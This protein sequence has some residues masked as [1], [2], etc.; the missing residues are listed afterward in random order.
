MTVVK[1]KKLKL[2]KKN[3]LIFLSCILLIL[4]SITYGV[5]TLTSPKTTKKEKVVKTA[6]EIKL[7][8][9][10]NIQKK[11]DY[12]NEDYIDRYLA[13]QKK[14]K[15]LS[16]KQ[17]IMD[18][19][20]GVDRD[21]YT[22][23]KKA[24]NLN[25]T[26]ILVNKY[27]YLEEDYIPEN[28]EEIDKKY[29]RNGMMLVKEAKEAFEDLA[30]AAKEEGNTIIAM[31]TYRSYNYQRALYN[32]YKEEDGVEGADTYSARAGFSE[33]QT[34]LAVDVYNGKEDYTNFEKTEEFT[35]MQ[36][37]AQNYGFILRFPEDKTKQTGYEYESWHYRYVGK[38]IATYIKKHHMCLEEYYVEQ[39]ENK[40]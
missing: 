29:A 30:Q 37:H 9:L 34:G 16:I 8:K 14:N 23:T 6:K 5:L 39:I 25:K 13:Y 36:E 22:N 40:K 38:K 21:Y 26:N 10:E 2:K 15:G 32:R 7:G 31:S 19:N 18:V 4:F 24:I 11:L 1:K 27:Y 12:F 35:W 20:I 17:I 33:H 28:L 3:F